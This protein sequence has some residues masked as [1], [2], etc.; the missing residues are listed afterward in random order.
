MDLCGLSACPWETG[1]HYK[2]TTTQVS[3][4]PPTCLCVQAVLCPEGWCVLFAPPG[5]EFR[6]CCARQASPPYCPCILQVVRSIGLLMPAL[7]WA[8]P[9]SSSLWR[10]V[11][12]QGMEAYPCLNPC[13]I[14][15]GWSSA[16][17]PED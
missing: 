13:G 8:R 10:L 11:H 7:V 1:I 16:R 6:G 2:A 3:S 12:V 4:P 17:S 9:L 15:C 14:P 5:T